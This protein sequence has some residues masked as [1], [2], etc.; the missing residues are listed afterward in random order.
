MSDEKISG[1][2]QRVVT[3]LVEGDYSGLEKL[4]HGKRLKAE[5]M[6]QAVKDYGST[7]MM[8]PLSAF[9][10]L[11]IVEVESARL[12]KWSVRFDLWTVS[13]GMSDLSLELTIT[14]VSKEEFE[15]EIDNI[16]VL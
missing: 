2:I 15:V 14:E 6:A 3:M 10:D 11:D 4:T 9:N 8:P 13:E 12:R 16:H 1:V 7:L 5:E